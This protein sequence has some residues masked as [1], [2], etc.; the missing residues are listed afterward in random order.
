MG[1][2]YILWQARLCDRLWHVCWCKSLMPPF[3]RNEVVRW[4]SWLYPLRAELRWEIY[5]TD[6]L[7]VPISLVFNKRGVTWW[8]CDILVIRNITSNNFAY[9]IPFWGSN[10]LKLQVCYGSYLHLIRS[11][12]IMFKI[13]IFF[14]FFKKIKKQ[15][16]YPFWGVGY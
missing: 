16:K 1:M 6:S 5:G 7:L 15:F 10:L 13:K 9:P 4:Y 8:A 14:L 11:M 12:F 3:W 2:A